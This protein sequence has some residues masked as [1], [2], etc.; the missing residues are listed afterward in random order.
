MDRVRT[1]HASDQSP[2]D[3]VWTEPSFRTLSAE[4]EEA[5]AG[6]RGRRCMLLSDDDVVV[7]PWMACTSWLGRPQVGGRLDTQLEWLARPQSLTM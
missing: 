3:S 5:G 7:L 1:S 2:A 4:E 6:G